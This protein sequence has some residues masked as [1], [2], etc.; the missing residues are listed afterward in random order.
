[1]IE[2][3]LGSIATLGVLGGLMYLMYRTYPAPSPKTKILPPDKK[4]HPTTPAK[5]FGHPFV[6]KPRTVGDL[7]KWHAWSKRKYGKT[8]LPTLIENGVPTTH[9]YEATNWGEMPPMDEKAARAIVK[10]G[11]RMLNLY[12]SLREKGYSTKDRLELNHL[13]KIL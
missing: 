1:M 7:K 2:D 13:E 6:A 8:K 5:T 11:E 9:A 3:K 12:D 4:I 10:K